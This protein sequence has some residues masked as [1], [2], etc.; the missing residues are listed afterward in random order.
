MEQPEGTGGNEAN[1]A[2]RDR[3]SR[4]SEASLRISESLDPDTVLQEVMDNAR[5]LT[6]ARFGVITPYDDTGRVE[7]FPAHGLTAKEAS[8]Y[9]SCPI[10]GPL[11]VRDWSSWSRSPDNED[12]SNLSMGWASL[13]LLLVRGSLGLIGVA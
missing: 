8:G 7:D 12:R 11:R 2:V 3:L 1:N 9:G 13:L 6:G 5:A 10:R 4:L